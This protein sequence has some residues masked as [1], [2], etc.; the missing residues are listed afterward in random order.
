VRQ[1][2][3]GEVRQRPQLRRPVDLLPH[4]TQAEILGLVLEPRDGM[5]ARR[6]VEQMIQGGCVRSKNAN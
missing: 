2:A 3:I 6:G 1:D 5:E 4:L